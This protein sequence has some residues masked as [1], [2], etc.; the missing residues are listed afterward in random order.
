M[1]NQLLLFFLPPSSTNSKSPILSH[2]QVRLEYP[3]VVRIYCRA[4]CSTLGGPS[5]SGVISTKSGAGLAR[6]MFFVSKELGLKLQETTQQIVKEMGMLLH[7]LL[8]EFSGLAVL[9]HQV[10]LPKRVPL[11]SPRE[12]VAIIVGGGRKTTVKEDGVV[13]LR[14]RHGKKWGEVGSSG[15]KSG[16][17]RK[18]TEP[19]RRTPS[20]YTLT[21]M[22]IT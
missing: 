8:S 11:P 22:I 1:N 16:E 9:A 2:L 6:V 12:V 14:R 20:L 10:L 13:H 4:P 18:D 15:S 5:N 19:S 21:H 17:G 3:C 7:T